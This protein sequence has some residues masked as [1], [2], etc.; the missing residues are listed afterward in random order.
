MLSGRS[1]PNAICSAPTPTMS[2][3]FNTSRA[4]QAPKDSSTID[5]AYLPKLFQGEFV[6]EPAKF[7]VPV[8]PNI[9][10]DDAEARLEQYPSLEAAAGGYQGT[11]G[12]VAAVMTP[13]IET[14]AQTTHANL[15]H[16]SDVGDGHTNEMSV[17]TLSQLSDLLG[18]NAKKFVEM[19]KDKDESTIRKIWSGFLDDIF[20]G[21]KSTKP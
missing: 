5:F 12:G 14:A 10:S 9:F 13:Q 17:E 7:R 8:L 20:G 3:H 1:E 11:D 4:H 2:R 19:V 18:S 21:S 6:P 16:M 15:S